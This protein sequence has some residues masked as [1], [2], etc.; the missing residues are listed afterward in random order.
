[1]ERGM[2]ESDD[3]KGP[4]VSVYIGGVLPRVYTDLQI[5]N[6]QQIPRY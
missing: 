4:I 5:T 3:L 6:S 2:M 1:M